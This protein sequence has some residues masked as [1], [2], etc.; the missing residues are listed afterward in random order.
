MNTDSTDG[1][2]LRK[3]ILTS[4]CEKR[5]HARSRILTSVRHF[6]PLLGATSSLVF[7]TDRCD[8]EAFVMDPRCQKIKG[9]DSACR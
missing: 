1:R 2:W 3:N 4:A 9:E 6:E 5:I 7:S 8:Y